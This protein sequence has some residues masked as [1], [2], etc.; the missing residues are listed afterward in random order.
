MRTWKDKPWAIYDLETT[1]LEIGQEAIR[2]IGVLQTDGEA[3]GYLVRPWKD[4]PADLVEKLHISQAYIE[5]MRAAEPF[6]QELAARLMEQ[7]GDRIPVSFNGM[8]F[9]RPFLAAEMHRVG[10]SSGAWLEKPQ[11]D[12]LLLASRTAQGQLMK[13]EDVARRFNVHLPGAHIAAADCAMTR[14]ILEAM[15]PVLPDD[16]D[17][18]L[19]LQDEEKDAKDADFE[20]YKWWLRRVGK[21]FRVTCGKNRGLF[22]DEVDPGFLSWAMKL[23]DLPPAVRDVFAKQV[24]WSVK[25]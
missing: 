13:L 4:I 12:V 18:L 17:E 20:L 2:E 19:E 11:I 9:D 24:H 16:L 22:V 7:I 1:G 6:S 8:T 14:G 21:R 5:Q 15:A 25:L 10:F 3:F 23:P